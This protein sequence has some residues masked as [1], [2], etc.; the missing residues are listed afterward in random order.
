MQAGRLP[1]G[2]IDAVGAPAATPP[3]S[4]A[5]AVQAALPRLASAWPEIGGLASD[6]VFAASHTPFAGRTVAWGD[7]ALATSA[8]LLGMALHG[9]ILPIADLSLTACDA[10]LAVLR[11]ASARGLRLVLLVREDAPLPEGLRAGL[12]SIQGARIFRPADAGEAL[13]CLA[14]ALRHVAAP[15]LL[16]LGDRAIAQAPGV[17][18]RSCARGGYVLHETARRDVTLI[19]SGAEVRLART[20]RHDLDAASVTAACVSLPCWQLFAAQDAAYRDAVLGSAPRIWL[21][22]VRG[23]GGDD[24]FI[25]S[26]D[27]GDVVA[28]VVRALKRP[29]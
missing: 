1:A 5:E 7:R 9:G 26:Q 11:A 16:L 15:S 3:I 21:E 27:S 13:E 19:A 6:G 17:P 12:Q 2:G 28:A 23:L 8:G 20:A 10:A 24:V 25:D 4:P 14:L 22:T 29:T 18:A